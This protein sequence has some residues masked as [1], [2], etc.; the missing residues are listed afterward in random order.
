MA[1][2]HVRFG[3]ALLF[4][5]LL[6]FTWL[7][8]NIQW[9][10]GVYFKIIRKDYSGMVFSVATVFLWIVDALFIAGHPGTNAA[11]VFAQG[12]WLG[13]LVYLNF[14]VTAKLVT[15]WP[16][17]DYKKGTSINFGQTWVV[18]LDTLWGTLL[19][20]LASLFAFLATS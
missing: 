17:Y 11:D 12:A 19:L 14:N 4:V 2:F 20:S 8:I 1:E 9:E 13:S 6:D 7:S 5:S 10:K 16:A 3:Y 18:F 15:D